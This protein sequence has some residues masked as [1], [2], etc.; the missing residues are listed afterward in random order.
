[1]QNKS[2]AEMLAVRSVNQYRRRDVFAYLGLRYYLDNLAAR[3]DIWAQDAAISLL[4]TRTQVGYFESQ[5]FK[6]FDA[7]GHVIHR[8]LFI[9]GANEAYAE[10]ALLA[11]CAKYEEFANPDCVY[12]YALAP[13][14]CRQGVFVNYFHGLQARHVAIAK[15]CEERPNSVVR[16]LDVKRFY[17]SISIKVANDAWKRYAGSAGLPDHFREC[18]EKLLSNYVI[19]GNNALLT[20]PMFSHLVANL[21]MRRID[22]EFVRSDRVQYIRYVDDV[23]LIG[24]PSDVNESF[25]TLRA[26]MRELDLDLHADDSSKSFE[27]N[28]QKWL[29]G[30]DDFSHEKGP[31]WLHLIRWT[32]QLLVRDPANRDLLQS[33]FRRQEIRLPIRDY[34]QVIHEASFLDWIIQMSRRGWF[35][36][37]TGRITLDKVVALAVSLRD[38]YHQEFQELVRQAEQLEGY[39]RKRIIPKLRFRASRLIYL[40]SENSL[41]ELAE[42]ISEIPELAFHAHVM[43][44]VATG[45]IDQVLA[46]GVNA[47]QAAAQ[48]LRASEKTAITS[49]QFFPQ[50]KGQS[51]AIFLMNGVAVEYA[52]SE[53][54]KHGLI[55]FARKGANLEMM[56]SDDYAIR[57]I[58]CLHGIA[59]PR[60][61]VMFENAFDEDESLVLD[62]IDQLNQ[63]ASHG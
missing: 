31:S 46:M 38:K 36:R 44:G 12:S 18:G 4:K 28:S 30:K 59:K 56:T 33:A 5:H 63:S 1:M 14:N 32:K 3:K 48:P 49:L 57:E 24:L 29:E 13:A 62:A 9:P 37:N 34:S 47:A 17:P 45:N 10:T 40:A 39:D 52:T 53:E 20:G 6:E 11:E 23:I 21:V 41:L 35:R 43:E 7:D 54:T 55:Q 22:E 58:A 51:L 15:A 26:R 27:V 16:Y 50:T 60:H 25:E 61:P 42:S 19:V 8:A 2:L